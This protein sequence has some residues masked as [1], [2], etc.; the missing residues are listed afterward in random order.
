MKLICGYAGRVK[1]FRP[2]FA[3]K[4][5]LGPNSQKVNNKNHDTYILPEREVECKCK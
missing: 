4:K 2:I 5:T 1:D 3:K